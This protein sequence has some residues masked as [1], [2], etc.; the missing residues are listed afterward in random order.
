[1]WQYSQYRDVQGNHP[2]FVYTPETHQITSPVPLIIMLHGCGQTAVDFAT[3]TSMNLLAEQHGFVVLYPQQASLFNP[4]RCW[5]WFLSAHQLRGHGEPA[6]IVGMINNLRQQ[7]MPWTID[8]ARIYVAGLSAGASMATI[9]GTTYPGLFAAIGIHSGLEYQAARSVKGA[10]EAMQRGGPDPHQQGRM[11]YVAMGDFSRVVPTIVFQGTD[12]T[13][14]SPA[15]GDQVVKQWLQTNYLASS[16]TVAIDLHY[17]T[18]TVTG[19]VAHGYS[20]TVTTWHA[21]NGDEVQ[22][23]WEIGS[24][25]HA[26]S[27]GNPAGSYTDARG[28]SASLAMYNFF[29][30]HPMSRRD[31]QRIIAQKIRQQRHAWEATPFLRPQR[32]DNGRQS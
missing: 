13:T 18:R 12:D 1:M 31:R 2:Y 24:M 27:G 19:Q 16:N 26:W 8:P 21:S 23:Y 6:R 3:G 17:S 9:L 29:M 10:F 14:V 11:A 28:P 7:N 4:R 5:N 20:Y 22:A 30:A 32:R 15:N 25:G